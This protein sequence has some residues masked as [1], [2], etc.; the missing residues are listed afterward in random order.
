MRCEWANSSEAMQAYHDNEWG[1]P[2]RDERY[3]FEMLT[4]EGAQAGLSWATIIK[5]RE[6]Y[7]QAYDNFEID[8]VASYDQEKRDSML[9]DK[10]IIRNR[11]KVDS[12]ISN[13]RV[14]QEM[15]Q[16]D[17]KFSDYIWNFVDNKPIINHYSDMSEMPAQTK[18]SQQ[19]SKDLKK[20]GFRFVGPTIIY[21]FL[22]AVGV[23]NDHIDSCNYK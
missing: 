15:H 11:L 1:K 18:L 3:F 14:I 20:R 16:K 9:Q 17:E 7:R 8:K 21:S 10:G 6:T 12:S 13:A 2:S 22:Q 4:L 5:R 23:I 19:I